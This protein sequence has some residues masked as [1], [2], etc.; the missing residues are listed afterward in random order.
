MHGPSAWRSSLPHLEIINPLESLVGAEDQARNKPADMFKHDLEGYR[1]CRLR[2]P[3]FIRLA[4]T[5]PAL[6]RRIC[7]R[8]NTAC[9]VP[10]GSAMPPGRSLGTSVRRFSSLRQTHIFRISTL[11]QVRVGPMTALRN[12]SGS[13]VWPPPPFVPELN[14]K[15]K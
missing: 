7:P 4:S 11:W 5:P 14:P 3:T 6:H 12:S 10:A 1:F 8:Q 2:W 15:H 13:G 9:I